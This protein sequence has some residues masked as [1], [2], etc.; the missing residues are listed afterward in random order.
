MSLLN[1]FM[2]VTCVAGIGAITVT[3]LKRSGIADNVKK[4]L[5]KFEKPSVKKRDKKDNEQCDI[6][7]EKAKAEF[8]EKAFTDVYE[9]IYR[10]SRG[11]TKRS[12]DILEDLDTRI[13]Y[14]KGSP[15]LQAYWRSI[16]ADYKNFTPEKLKDAAAEF[17]Q[18]VFNAGIQRDNSEQVTVD[19]TTHHKYYNSNDGD[20]VKGEIM[21]VERA[22][23][24]L[25]GKILEKGELTSL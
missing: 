5:G 9:S 21:K 6:D 20:F 13:Y 1:T 14:M 25:G 4:I 22:C 17:I 12:N 19:E 16:F 2:K 3:I 10:V 8:A 18:F 15:N 7:I 24:S 23:W 11:L